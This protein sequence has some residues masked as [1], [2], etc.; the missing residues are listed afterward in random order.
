MKLENDKK[1]I[2]EIDKIHYI[3]SMTPLVELFEELNNNSS[4]ENIITN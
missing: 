3:K 4:Q 1:I 2:L